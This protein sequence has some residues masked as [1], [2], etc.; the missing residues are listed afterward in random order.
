VS[1]SVLTIVV[2]PDSLNPDTDLD[3]AFQEIPDADTGQPSSPIREHPALPKLK[4]INCF[5]FFCVILALLDPDP[6]CVSGSRD[7]IEFGSNPDSNPHGPF[8][9]CSSG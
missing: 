1:V 4:F 9:I 3:P 2:D 7:P 5:L 8:M 6:D